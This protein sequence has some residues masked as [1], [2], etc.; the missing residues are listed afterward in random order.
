VRTL[1]FR[2][3][4]LA[5]ILERIHTQG[6]RFTWLLPHAANRGR[7]RREEN[8]CSARRVIECGHGIVIG[9]AAEAALRFF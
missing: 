3:E 7:I 2:G 6:S 1:G 4:A 9:F 5:F 8:R